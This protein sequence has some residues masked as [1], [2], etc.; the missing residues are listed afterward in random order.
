MDERVPNGLEISLRRGGPETDRG[1]PDN[2]QRSHRFAFDRVFADSKSQAHVYRHC[3][4]DVVRS[5]LGGYNGTLFAYGQ[6]GSGKTFT[7]TGGPRF[8]E[9]GVIPRALAEVFAHLRKHS[10]RTAFSLF[11]S[12]LE[13]YNES[14]YDLLDPDHSHL[15]IDKWP[16]VGMREG[17]D[18]QLHLRGL[19]VYETRAEEDALHLL[20]LGN[21]HRMTAE[22]A[23]NRA[24][25]R[26][27][28]LFSLTLEQRD[29]DSDVVR[30]S[31]LHL[32]DLAGSERVAKPSAVLMRQRISHSAPAPDAA[33]TASSVLGGPA[34]S[35]G[36]RAASPAPTA[37][38][39]A[40]ASSSASIVSAAS[41]DPLL[42]KEGRYINLSLHYLEK[43]ILAL[44]ARSKAQ[45]QQGVGAAA[46]VHVPYRNSVITSVLRDSLGGN[47]K[48]AFIAALNAEAGNAE[49]SLSTC[50][51]VQRCG[52]LSSNV[53]VNEQ[54]DVGA[55]VARLER[56]RAVWRAQAENLAMSRQ[57]VVSA[58]VAPRALSAAASASCDKALT[59]FLRSGYIRDTQAATGAALGTVAPP[60]MQWSPEI[61]VEANRRMVRAVLRA[62]EQAHPPSAARGA[63]SS[64]AEA[65]APHSAPAGRRSESVGP[66]TYRRGPEAARSVGTATR[67]ARASAPRRGSGRSS[68]A[69][70]SRRS[71][72]DSES[73]R[74]ASAGRAR[75]GDSWP[76]SQPGLDRGG[77]AESRGGS[78]SGGA[79]PAPPG[80]RE[81]VRVLEDGDLLLATTGRHSTLPRP[82]LR[83]SDGD[84][85][86][87][88]AAGVPAGSGEGGRPTWGGMSSSASA[89]AVPAEAA[90]GSADVA[91]ERAEDAVLAALPAGWLRVRSMAEAQWCLATMRDILRDTL[92][93]WSSA[94]TRLEAAMA[95]PNGSG[96]AYSRAEAA[97][98]LPRPPRA[99]ERA[100]GAHAPTQRL[101]S[102]AFQARDHRPTSDPSNSDDVEPRAASAAWLPVSSGL[103]AHTAPAEPGGA[104]A[105][106][107]APQLDQSPRAAATE[108]ALE[109]LEGDTAVARAL[110]A[111]TPQRVP[112]AQ[113]AAAPVSAAKLHFR[114]S[115]SREMQSVEPHADSGP[116]TPG[117]A[118][119]SASP[120]VAPPPTAAR[121]VHPPLPAH[122]PQAL[123]PSETPTAASSPPPSPL[124]GLS[125]LALRGLL[126]NGAVFL[127]HRASSPPSSPAAGR[128]AGP[129]TPPTAL[130]FVWCSEDLS[131][132]F[133]RHVGSADQ[134][135]GI[136]ASS[137]TAVVA[138]KQTPA[139]LRGTGRDASPHCCFSII[140]TQESLDLQIKVGGL[141]TGSVASV[142]AEARA[143]W[144]AAFQ[145]LLDR[146]GGGVAARRPAEA[147]T[148]VAAELVPGAAESGHSPAAAATERLS[149]A[150]SPQRTEHSASFT[151]RSRSLNPFECL[152][153]S[154]SVK[155]TDAAGDQMSTLSE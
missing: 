34:S 68:V 98:A 146:R 5:F 49:E 95:L 76:R 142:A 111:G 83:L 90:I 145:Y 67:G 119:G 48:T 121:P 61:L 144:V 11:V 107:G 148:Q 75:P 114:V 110:E 86:H 105:D 10:H 155:T 91:V 46:R 35:L 136:A 125:P 15:P 9:R 42:R 1:V 37:V 92:F 24:S 104:E 20:F 100:G 93:K 127:R 97:D 153:R 115:Q 87:E 40:A 8:A 74:P 18:G 85:D 23:M 14:V 27:H 52:M 58:Y 6:T 108:A 66:M 7:I 132:L 47:C 38:S 109:A 113:A 32:V 78:R 17:A 118:Q 134:V 135:A 77:A 3:A 150:T 60:V 152:A 59:E 71:S 140:S 143:V 57:R 13:V 62:D 81:P 124:G 2:Q 22:T 149:R 79:S 103:P 30:S 69:L 133:W 39:A 147:A 88:D 29:L 21:A 96:G 56:Q 28:C 128:S 151:N 117:T 4:A 19:R 53:I 112:Q 82:R 50:R 55:V 139:L 51:F 72:A 131:T 101:A 154:A 94:E 36:G 99:F 26:S 120:H 123:S 16:K 41:V 31:K 141:A 43:V 122:W 130:Q 45:A 106:T 12:Y 102:R 89:N 138:G 129:E 64:A 63:R 25:S 126:T 80:H 54:R 70:R 33:E 116:A 73:D 65:A 44:Y 84:A 137:I